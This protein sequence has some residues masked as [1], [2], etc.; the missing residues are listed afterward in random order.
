MKISLL[1]LTDGHEILVRVL[2]DDN[3]NFILVEKA[4]RVIFQ[5]DPQTQQTG[6]AF[7]PW[8]QI[9]GDG[10]LEINRAHIISTINAVPKSLEDAYLTQTSGLVSA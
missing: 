5:Q 7:P 3:T 8:S 10:E 6:V 9:A 4:R 2:D 1:K